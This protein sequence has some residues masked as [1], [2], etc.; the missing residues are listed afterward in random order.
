[1]FCF[2]FLS[3]YAQRKIE[4]LKSRNIESDRQTRRR[5]TCKPSH[6]YIRGIELNRYSECARS[7]FQVDV[8]CECVCCYGGK[9]KIPA[10]KLETYIFK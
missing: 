1:M 6:M 3:K 9:A 2:F 5:T 8:V 10:R 7:V 4:L